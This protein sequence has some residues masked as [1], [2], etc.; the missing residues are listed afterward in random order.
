M[1]HVCIEGNVG[2]GKTETIKRLQTLFPNAAVI[3]EPA[4]EWE[5]RGLLKQMYDDPAAY[6]IPFQQAA[7]VGLFSLHYQTTKPLMITERS[8]YSNKHVFSKVHLR[9][10]ESRNYEYTYDCIAKLMPRRDVLYFHLSAPMAT[11]RERIRTRNRASERA[12]DEAYLRR[13]DAAHREWLSGRPNVVEVDATLPSAKI[14]DII[15]T[16][17][18]SHLLARA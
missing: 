5:S 16:E 6:G 2:V 9:G 7:L 1:L 3:E 8:I 18:V 14:A 12:V 17:I 13:V 15:R 11:L 10:A 4:G